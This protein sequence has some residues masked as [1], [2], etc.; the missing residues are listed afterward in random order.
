M[1]CFRNINRNLFVFIFVMLKWSFMK[2]SN[3]FK[4]KSQIH[5]RYVVLF[6]NFLTFLM[7]RKTSFLMINFFVFENSIVISQQ[8]K[9]FAETRHFNEI[10]R[11]VEIRNE[12]CISNFIFNQKRNLKL[13]F[14][15]VR[16]FVF[17][18]FVKFC[19]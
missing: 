4:K 17:K 3:F 2:S 6:Y 1:F 19:L 18:N 14:R 10:F 8:S 5:V 11:L 16:K 7:R 15:F 9:L 13:K 12:I